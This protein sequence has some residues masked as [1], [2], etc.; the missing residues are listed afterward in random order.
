MTKIWIARALQ[1][2]VVLFMLFDSSIKLV[3]I[4]PVIDAFTTL[5]YDPSQARLIGS[6][7]LICTLLY[8]VPRTA[9][10]GAVLLTGIFGGAIASHLR[11]DDPLFTHTLFGLYLGG[12]MWAPL[13]LRDARLRQLLPLTAR[14]A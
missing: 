3:K 7:E 1:A 6:I 11:L 8:L 13:F 9:V 4:Q 12:M 5:G 2:L 10:L 14:A